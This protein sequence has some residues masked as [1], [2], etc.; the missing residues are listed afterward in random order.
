MVRD[1]NKLGRKVKV[2]NE[3]K[4]LPHSQ[5]VNDVILGQ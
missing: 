4:V 2:E 3:S 1:N 5:S